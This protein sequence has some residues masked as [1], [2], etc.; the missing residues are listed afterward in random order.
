[1]FGRVNA[2]PSP[3]TPALGYRSL[4]RWYDL[5]VRL[6]LPEQRLRKTL[7]TILAAQPG[8]TVLDFGSGTGKNLALLCESGVP[9]NLHGVDIDADV[10]PIA[11]RR[12]ARFPSKPELT[13][14]DGLRLPYAGNAFDRVFSMQV[15]HHLTTAQKGA[16]LLE[17]KRVLKPGGLMVL[18]DWGKPSN[19]MMRAGYVG[20]QLVDGFETTQDNCRGL[21]PEFISG[22]GFS[23]VMEVKRLNTLLGTFSYSTGR[24]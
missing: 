20:V 18:A 19:V 6:T 10:L 3:F 1:L 8:E 23:D 13:L 21:L 22:A 4:T 5:A 16:A 11:K 17:L 14:Y 24:G 15:F 2:E 12:L 7:L 9:L